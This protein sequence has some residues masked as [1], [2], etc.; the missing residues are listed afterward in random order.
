MTA[1][2]FSSRRPEVDADTFIAEGARLVGHVVLRAGASVWYNSVLRAD[3]E[4][5]VVGENTNI[6]DNCAVHV[7]AGL[8]TRLGAHVTVGHGAILHACTVEDECII[9]MGAV[10]LDGAVIRR[11][12]IVGAGAL[13]PPRKSFPP[14]SLLLGSPAAVVRTLTDG[15][16]RHHADHARQYVSF[17]RAYKAGGIGRK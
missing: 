8:P 14:G 17:W 15:E 3:L 16:V 13:V 10:I 6:Q 5:I 4:D 7:D 12:S 11:G 9:G 1:Y 2:D